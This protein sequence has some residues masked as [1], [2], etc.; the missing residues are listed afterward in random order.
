MYFSTNHYSNI[1]N[2]ERHERHLATDIFTLGT[3]K[4]LIS[5]DKRIINLPRR[6]ESTNMSFPGT[7]YLLIAF[8]LFN[9]G[10]AKAENTIIGFTNT[11]PLEYNLSADTTSADSEP[12]ESG[13]TVGGH[14]L[15][16]PSYMFQWTIYPLEYGLKKSETTLLPYLL[17][18]ERGYYGVFPLFELGGATGYSYGLLLFHNRPFYPNHSARIEALFGS[19]DYNDFDFEYDINRFLSDRGRLEIEA[20][21]GNRPDRTYLFGNDIS[22]DKRS[23]YDREDIEA[24]L[25]YSYELTD[26]TFLTFNTDYLRR[27]ITQSDRVI[28]DNAPA[29]P[30]DF[31]GN[32]ALLSTGVNL[33]IDNATGVPRINRGSRFITDLQWSRS[34]TNDRFHY[35]NYRAEWN[36]F[37]PIPF[38]P[39]DRRLAFKSE[40][41]KAESLG[42]KE[43]P[44]FETPSLGSSHDLRGF[45]TNRFRD[46]GSLLFT[47]EYRYPLWDFSD[48]VLFV[49]EGQVFNRY[50][51][52]GINDFHTSYGFGFH[53]I[54]SKGFAFRSEFAFSRETSRFILLISPNF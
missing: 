18:G 22:F 17:E 31:L 24:A 5:S 9:T 41:H 3:F 16:L 14:L 37:I 13:K 12:Y 4:I 10:V 19:S 46:T 52:I 20:T 25:S 40:L 50:S 54:S 45:S 35:I 51:D 23:F 29:F 43:I 28:E 32:N 33:T 53:L 6:H 38:L 44:F 1:I 7:I 42:D 8:F 2:S 47:L 36:Q 27:K 26:R 11:Q 48:V 21:Y 39:D 15:S 30:G 34:L 49:D